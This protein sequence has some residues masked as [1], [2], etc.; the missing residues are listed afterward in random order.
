[1]TILSCPTQLHPLPIPAGTGRTGMYRVPPNNY[2]FYSEEERYVP[3]I[4][5]DGGQLSGAEGCKVDAAIY[6]A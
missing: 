6:E 4:Q 3:V 5:A 1:M 2:P